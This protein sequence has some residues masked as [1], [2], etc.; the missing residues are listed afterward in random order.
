M[1]PF[2]ETLQSHKG[3]LIKLKTVLYWYDGRGWDKNP[4]QVCLLLDA[5]DHDVAIA[6]A[7]ATADTDTHAN[8]DALLLIEGS[9]QWVWVSH[10]DVEFLPEKL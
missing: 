9:P 1:T 10:P 8:P 6:V 3:G 4:G 5:V 2:L 7:V